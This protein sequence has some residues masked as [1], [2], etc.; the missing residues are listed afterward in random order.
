[1]NGVVDR[2]DVYEDGG[3]LYFRVVDYKTG[4]KAFCPTSLNTV[5]ACRCLFIFSPHRIIFQKRGKPPSP[6]GVLYMPAR[7]AGISD[8]QSADDLDKQ[9]RMKGIVLDDEKIIEAMDPG[10][11]GRYIPVSFSTSKSGFGNILSS[12]YSSIASEK[13][14]KRPK[15]KSPK[16]WRKWARTYFAENFPPTLLIPTETAAVNTATIPLYAPTRDRPS[17]AAC[18]SSALNREKSFYREASPMSSKFKATENQQKGHRRKG[19]AARVRRRRLGQDGH[20]C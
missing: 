7:E 8:G 19:L 12:S 10:R 16:Y 17:T 11:T 4:K 18:R 1:M 5:S 2:L 3:K 13:F 20:P 6:A 9:L 14:F 15:N